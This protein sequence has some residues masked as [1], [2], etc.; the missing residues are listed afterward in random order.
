MSSQPAPTIEDFD[1]QPWQPM[2]G[3]NQ[4]WYQR[5]VQYVAMGAAR[6]V[7][8]VY[9]AEQRHLGKGTERSRAVPASWTQAAK[10]FEWQRR[11][12]A[13]DAHERQ[14]LLAAGNAS[15][16]ERI[17]KLDEL[18]ERMQQRLI[19][20]ID[21]VAVDARFIERYLGVLD[22]LAKHT[23]GYAA[24]RVELSGKDGKAIQVESDETST[25]R[26]V[27][28]VP[29]VGKIDGDNPALDDVSPGG[30]DPALSGEQGE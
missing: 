14:R 28:Y 22:L 30:E 6:S 23:G 1:A 19:E 3:E 18:A 11:A 8:G 27:F 25:M 10:R 5:F 4:R 7:R 9:N 26:V 29:E 12:A 24:Q 20:R 16:L 17:A 15:D 21:F 2:P 13:F